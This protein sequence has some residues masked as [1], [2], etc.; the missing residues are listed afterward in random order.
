MVAPARQELTVTLGLV[1]VLAVSAAAQPRQG[2]PARGAAGANR[3]VPVQRDNAA[4]LERANAILGQTL[5]A[6]D[7]PLPDVVVRLRNLRG[8]GVLQTTRSDAEGRFAF[9]RVEPGVY[10]SEMI[11]PDEWVGAVSEAVTIGSNETRGMLLRLISNRRSFAWWG[12]TA[13]S[14]ALAAASNL[15]V[16]AVDEGVAASTIAPPRPGQR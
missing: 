6:Q 16:L 4:A 12:G 2:Q 8:N 5:D 1:L 9:H 7:R 11:L 14:I 3:I 15:G 10:V 13:T